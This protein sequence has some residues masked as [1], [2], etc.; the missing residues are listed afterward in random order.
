[1][2]IKAAAVSFFRRGQQL[3]C[4]R[5]GLAAI[6]FALLAP[7]LLA[8]YFLT[9][10][11]GRAIEAN[12]KVDRI[13]G[14]VGDL[15]T[16]QVNVDAADLDAIMRIGEATL[17]PYDR[18]QPAIAVTAIEISDEAVPRARVAWSRKLAGGAFS[19]GEAKDEEVTVPPS[20]MIA[21]SFLIRAESNLAYQ[22][23]VTWAASG[24]KSLGFDSISMG[25]TY[26]LRPRMSRTISCADC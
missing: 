25:E 3:F 8:L 4:D 5:R 16:Q 19:A 2:T 18:S 12:G 24:E 13:G 7:L 9:M 26:Y 21:G 17:Q 14:M 20:L 23:V 10:E 15:V 1:M 6:E 22:P 11:T